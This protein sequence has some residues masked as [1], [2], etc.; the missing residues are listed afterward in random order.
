VNAAPLTTKDLEE[1]KREHAGPG[2][3]VYFIS[4]R[5][6]ATVKSR[7]AALQFLEGVW[8]LLNSLETSPQ[9]PPAAQGLITDAK[10]ELEPLYL[11]AMGDA[12]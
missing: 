7:E 3:L 6:E 2:R 12:N 8:P 4:E 1:A 10:K 11:K 9:L 5:M